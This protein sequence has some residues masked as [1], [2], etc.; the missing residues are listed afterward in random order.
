MH[1]EQVSHASGDVP[2]NLTSEDARWFAS[3]ACGDDSGLWR[4]TI[5]DPAHSPHLRGF[6]WPEARW[7][8]TRPRGQGRTAQTGA[9]PRAPGQGSEPPPPVPTL[10][11]PEKGGLVQDVPYLHSRSPF[12]LTGALSG[13]K[14]AAKRAQRQPGGAGCPDTC[15][16]NA[17]NVR[18]T[19]GLG[20]RGCR[21]GGNGD[22]EGFTHAVT[23]RMPGR[24][25]VIA[26][27]R[28][29]DG[30]ASSHASRS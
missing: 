27:A 25:L 3:H 6:F 14:C 22:Q 18:R 29:W 24:Q 30:E 20:H 8:A 7:N 10:P 15:P 1:G 4:R 5:D 21:R 26:A 2:I 16:V 13:M 17:L 11:R 28:A 19:R 12:S 9:R 23:R